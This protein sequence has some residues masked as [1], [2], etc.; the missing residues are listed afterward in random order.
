MPAIESVCALAPDRPTWVIST[1]LGVEIGLYQDTGSHCKSSVSSYIEV[2][3]MNETSQ[4][5]SQADGSLSA[6]PTA[7]SSAKAG[8]DWR[9]PA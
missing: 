4:F 5:R 6:A 9:I 7:T 1:T 8:Q 2:A 3:Q